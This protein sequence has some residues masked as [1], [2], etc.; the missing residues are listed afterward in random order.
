MF[1]ITFFKGALD[2]GLI[3]M[4]SFYSLENLSTARAPG[5]LFYLNMTGMVSYGISILISNLRILSFSHSVSV[6]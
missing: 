1:L 5:S 4:I 3:M 2:A 6:F